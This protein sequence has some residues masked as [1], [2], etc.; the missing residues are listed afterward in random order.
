MKKMLTALLTLSALSLAAAQTTPAPI[1]LATAATVSTASLSLS[2]ASRIATLAVNNCAQLGYN[3][4][5]TVV[6]RSGVVLAVARSENAGPHTLGASQGKAFTSASARNLTSTIAKGL[7]A[8]P[9]L[10]DI[11]GYLVLAGGAPIRVDGAVVGAVGVGGA[12]SGL[13]DET[14]GTDAVTTVLGK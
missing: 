2:A 14:C 8:N 1:K 11:P 4:A 12:P 9:G 10:A 5:A 13:V 3:V 6:D 7:E